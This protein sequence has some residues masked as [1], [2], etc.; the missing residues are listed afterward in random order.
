LMVVVATI[1]GV[2]IRKIIRIKQAK[3]ALAGK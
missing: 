2:L 3:M 1:I